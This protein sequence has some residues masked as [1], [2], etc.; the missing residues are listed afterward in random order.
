MSRIHLNLP[1]QF[2]GKPMH[3]GEPA[4]SSNPYDRLDGLAGMRHSS[5]AIREVAER[6]GDLQARLQAAT[7][8]VSTMDALRSGMRT[9]FPDFLAGT[10]LPRLG[11]NAVFFAIDQQGETLLRGIS[12]MLEIMPSLAFLESIDSVSLDLVTGRSDRRAMAAG[13]DIAHTN[14]LPQLLNCTPGST[15]I[16]ISNR[17]DFGRAA[18]L[19]EYTAREGAQLILHDQVPMAARITGDHLGE[20]L[21]AHIVL[22][23]VSSIMTEALHALAGRKILTSK[24]LVSHASASTLIST[25]DYAQGIGAE[26][27]VLNQALGIAESS[28]LLP[29]GLR[30]SSP[31]FATYAMF[32]AVPYIGKESAGSP[33][34]AGIIRDQAIH[35]YLNATLDIT[36][37]SLALLAAERYGFPHQKATRVS[38]A[39]TLPDD[40]ARLLLATYYPPFLPAYVNGEINTLRR[41]PFGDEIL[42]DPHGPKNGLRLENRQIHLVLSRS[43]IDSSV[44]LSRDDSQVTEQT[45]DVFRCASDECMRSTAGLVGGLSTVTGHRFRMSDTASLDTN[46]L[47]RAGAAAGLRI[48]MD[49]LG[50]QLRLP[51]LCPAL[52]AGSSSFRRTLWQHFVEKAPMPA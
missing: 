24:N 12:N 4:P 20:G 25:L 21:T 30:T 44:R 14:Y 19:A 9:A 45:V 39:R 33:L 1:D 17:G 31:Q 49:V 36:M 5:P 43:R 6:V 48:V 29:E 2:R 37:R 8:V 51:L 41:S 10:V 15:V 35:T 46:Q 7:V 52:G 38:I 40:E 3:F 11:P 42:F 18:C 28:N 50:D 26:T 34:A 22:P 47:R 32:N 16:D 13:L 23:S 27:I